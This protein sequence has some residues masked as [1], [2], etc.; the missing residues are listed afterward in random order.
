MCIDTCH[1]FAAGYD[2]RTE[3]TY[4]KTWDKFGK[5]VGFKFLA[6]LHLNDSRA[7]LGAARDLHGNL[8]SFRFC[9]LDLIVGEVSLPWNRFG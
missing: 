8:G 1:A 2:L 7:P 9:N 5:I 3:E 6:G 4:N